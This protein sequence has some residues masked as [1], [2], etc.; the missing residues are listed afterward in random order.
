MEKELNEAAEAG[1]RFLSVMGG[2]TAVGGKEVVTVMGRSDGTR[3]R[4]Q[5]KLVATNKTSTMQRELQEAADQGFEYLGQTVF[6]SM[7]GGKEV[8]CI[9]QRSAARNWSPSP[10]DRCADDTPTH[11]RRWGPHSSRRT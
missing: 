11:G 8:V 3:P 1:F 9:L 5:Y 6:E 7:F 4:Y 2:E 10:D